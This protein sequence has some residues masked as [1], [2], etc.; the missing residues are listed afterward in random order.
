MAKVP[1]PERP[2]VDL[3]AQLGDTPALSDDDIYDRIIDAVI[4][5][6]LLPGTRLGEDKLGQVFGVS[7]TRIRQVLIRLA[8]EQVVTLEPNKGATVAQPTVEDAR[9][10]FEARALIEAVLVER[11]MTHATAQDL[12]SLADCIEAEELARR[13]GDQAAALRLSG[14]FHLLI[15]EVARH[16]TFARML[17]KLISRTSLILMSYAPTERARPDLGE[18][19]VRWVDACRCDAHRGVLTAL[20]RRKSGDLQAQVAH[21]AALMRQHLGDIEAGLC[22]N[23]LQ[24][25]TTDLNALLGRARPRP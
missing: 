4:D 10:V 16:Q 2:A 25:A 1:R 12:Q 19:P 6:R 11:F 9:E 7:R 24:E 23:Q 8:H 3:P 5:Q 15:A 18:A 14:R 13:E 17:K 21:G 22:F 20:R